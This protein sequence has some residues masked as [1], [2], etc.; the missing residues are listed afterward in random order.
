MRSYSLLVPS[1]TARVQILAPPLT[2]KEIRSKFS[3]SLILGLCVHLKSLRLCP[4]LC[5]SM[6]C[7]PP[8]ASVHGILQ[9]KYWSELPCPA[10]GDLPNP[11]IKPASH[12]SRI[13]RRLLVHLGTVVLEKTLESPLDFKEIKPVHS[14]GNQSWI[15]MGRTDAGAETPIPQPPDAK[16]WLIWKDFDAGKDWRQEKRMPEDEMAGWHH[17]LN[18]HEFE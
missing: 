9:A 14:K 8:G 13:G 5:D 17:P 12:A 6:D 4:T 16:N 10:P 3:T 11:E 18:G 15:F 7:R 1:P 2:L